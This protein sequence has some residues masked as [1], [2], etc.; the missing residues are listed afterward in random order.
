MAN[1]LDIWKF[2]AGLGI[3]LF[4]MARMEEAIKAL[5]GKRFKIF[6]K[7]SSSNR[8]LA[9]LNGALATA[10]LQSSSIILLLMIAFAGAGIVSLSNSLGIILGANLGT[11]MTG[12]LVSAIGF[13]ANIE[14]F[15]YPLLSIGSV[16]FLFASNRPRFYHFFSFCV[17]LGLLFLGLGYMKDS[18]SQLAAMVDLEQVK[19]L[20]LWAFFGIGFLITMI[21]QSSSG[22]MTITLGALHSGMVD[23][24]AAAYIAVGADLGTT[25]TALVASA[26]GTEVKKRIGLAHFLFNII[27][28]LVALMLI[29]PLLSLVRNVYGISDPL[30]SLTAFHSSFNLLGILIVFPFLGQFEKLLNRFYKNNKEYACHYIHRVGTEVPEAALEMTARELQKF[31]QL[32]LNFNASILGVP[33]SEDQKEAPVFSF[34]R[35]LLSE[36]DINDHYEKLKRI[37]GELLR[38]LTNLQKEKLT[39]EEAEKL[40]S[41]IVGLR[42]GVQSAKAMKDIRHNMKEFDQSIDEPIELLVKEF[43]HAYL[44][45]QQRLGKF[46]QGANSI[47]VSLNEMLEETHRSYHRV[48]EWIYMMAKLT[49]SMDRE[50]AT[51]L[52]VNREIRSAHS[53][54]IESLE[55]TLP[56]RPVE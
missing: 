18:M 34:F 5:A 52:N 23:L 3:F 15:V 8:F 4:G 35:S 46:I 10:L 54:L 53:L 14:S 6:L 22:M 11:T 13:K 29:Q 24:T 19:S 33:V 20:G 40:K 37:E 25:I 41:Y 43:H 16:G 7:R 38:Y 9:I 51:F 31:A 30:Y 56:I 32:V 21:I 44:P 42:N 48:N 36:E 47:S 12:W 49:P 39:D 27:T 1:T 17:A 45:I 55:Q 26:R 50:V 2:T 28:A